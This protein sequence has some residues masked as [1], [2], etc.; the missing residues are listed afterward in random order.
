MKQSNIRNLYRAIVSLTAFI[1]WT[2]MIRCID[3]K[4]IGPLYSS[5]GFAA[6]NK[7]IHSFTG[8]HM[9]LYHIT[10]WLGLI[11]IFVA[12][13]FAMLGLIQWIKRKS[14]FRV[15]RS[16]LLLGGFYLAVMATYLF[17]EQYIINYRPILI[18]GILE[19][20]YPSSTTILVL[21]VMPTAILQL[22][23]RI[24]KPTCRQAAIWAIKIFIIFMVVGRLIS[25]VHWFTDIIG[26]ALLSNG[27]VQL[28]AFFTK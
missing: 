13:G 21:T 26:G 18:E 6:F 23:D 25:G 12:F 7:C 27:L 14:F 4:P 2:A 19:A 3:V 15:D 24:Q 17:F 11:P 28:Y 10:D 22:Q 1:L 8:V 9:S 16:I 20:S 5:V